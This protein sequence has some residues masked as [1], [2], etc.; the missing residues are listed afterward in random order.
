M[1]RGEDVCL[2]LTSP[3]ALLPSSPNHPCRVIG[4]CSAGSACKSQMG[5]LD[6]KLERVAFLRGLMWFGWEA[7]RC[8][9]QPRLLRHVS[10]AI[11]NDGLVETSRWSGC[12]QG[13][14]LRLASHGSCVAGRRM[15]QSWEGQER[16]SS[17]LDHASQGEVRERSA[18]YSRLRQRDEGRQDVISSQAGKL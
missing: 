14:F 4:P 18:Y 1:V 5:V 17:N 2:H 11:S 16:L 12:G 6:A 3:A 13:R 10:V 15:W 8:G 9:Q 7:L